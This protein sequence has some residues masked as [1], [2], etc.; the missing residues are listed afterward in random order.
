MSAHEAPSLVEAERL[1]LA[2]TAADW[3]DDVDSLAVLGVI[4][5]DVELLSWDDDSWS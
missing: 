3:N 2:E 4:A 5:G 1:A